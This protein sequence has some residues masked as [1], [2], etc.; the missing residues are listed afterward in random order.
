MAH[1]QVEEML[2][3]I[4]QDC[5]ATSSYTGISSFAPEVMAAVARV[6]RE[7]FVPDKLKPWAYE[8][9][10]LPIGKGQTISQP[11]IVALMTDL[12]H[13]DKNDV[14]LEVGAGSGYQAAVL[15]QLVGRLYTLEIVPA[16]AKNAEAI[17]KNLGYQNVEV[18]QG[19][20]SK[21]WPEHAP[22]DGIIVTAAAER[23]PPALT[24]QLRPGGRLVIPVGAPQMPQDLLLI[25]KDEEGNIKRRAVLP[26]AFVPF[27][28]EGNKG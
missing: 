7:A 15:A 18:Q 24:E 11:F 12:L 26:V 17:L 3:K 10:P 25:R 2:R 14:V 28:S 13:P 21:G 23:I 1:G 20:A 4:E 6:P 9:R 19:D 5:R 27:T 8:N 16:L 22:F